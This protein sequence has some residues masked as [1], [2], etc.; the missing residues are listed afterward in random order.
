MIMILPSLIVL[1]DEP[2]MAGLI[3]N[4]AVQAG[5]DVKQINDAK[6]FKEY[7]RNDFDVLVLDLMMPEVDGIEII[8]FLSDVDC[9]ALLVLVS[10][11]DSGVLHSA[12]K[13]AIEKGLNYVGSLNKPFRYNELHTLLRGLS[14]S[15]KNTKKPTILEQ[16]PVEEVKNAILQN[17]FVVYYQPQIS[18]IERKIIGVEALLRWQHP[19]YGLLA[20]NMFIAT[21]EEN[22]L[23]DDLTWVVFEQ[24]IAHCSDYCRS[25]NIHV[26]INISAN[27]FW[28]I[29]LPEVISSIINRDG[30]DPSNFVLELTETA[31]MQDPGKS[32]DILTRLRMKGFRLSIDDFGTGYSS[33]AQLHRAPFSE[34]KI[35][36][37]F[38]HDM[39][40]DK[41]AR[42]IVETIVLLGH[43]LGLRVIAEG[44]EKQEDLDYLK[45]LKCDSVQGYLLAKPMEIN[46]LNEWISTWKKSI[47]NP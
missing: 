44:V 14:S 6:I 43:K 46:Q 23:I 4:V 15:A 11:F 41:E 36:R 18:V 25:Q 40:T 10:G 38:V 16:P 9:D 31:I 37:S 39:S 26:A 27:T 12:Q 1:D 24:A 7:F 17:E 35:D 34:I 8:R 42:A 47:K 30:L 2:D 21:A 20:P 32:L 29:Q 5:F 3:C 45:Q 22:G 28:N 19:E 13:L 33:L